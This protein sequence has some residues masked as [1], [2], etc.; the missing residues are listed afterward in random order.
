MN[1]LQRAASAAIVIAAL[2][3]CDQD[4]TSPRLATDA[5]AASQ[6][7]APLTGSRRFNSVRYGNSGAQRHGN[8]SG[9]AALSAEVLVGG[10]GPATFEATSHRAGGNASAGVIERVRLTVYSS[11]RKVL[12]VINVSGNGTSDL[13]VAL[14][15]LPAGAHVSA[16]A[17]VT[18]IDGRRTNVV[19]VANMQPVLRP[20]VAIVGLIIPDV[21]LAG[22][23]TVIGAVLAEQ[24]GARGASLD[25]VLYVDGAAADRARNVWV[26]AGDAVTCA[27]T[28]VF[29]ADAAIRVVAENVRPGDGDLSDNA[30]EDRLRVLAPGGSGAQSWF[31][32]DIRAGSYAATDS[33][34]TRWLAP[35]GSLFLEQVSASST[36]GTMQTVNVSGSIE[37]R[38]PFPLARIEI[39][40]NADGRLVGRTRLADVAPTAVVPGASCFSQDDGTGPFL[41]LCS[42]DQGFTSLLFMRH[43]GVVTYQSSE[44]SRVWN[45][46]SYDEN[47][48][49]V[50]QTDAS[51]TAIGMASHY[52]VNIRIASGGV[53]YGFDGSAALAP[54]DELTIEPPFCATVPLSLPPVT[55]QATSCYRSTWQFSGI[56]GLLAGAGLVT[57]P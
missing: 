32:G 43:A 30:A 12:D 14:P 29:S 16:T 21:A 22:A 31:S 3:A 6:G 18:G 45:G 2:S 4:S 55:Y 47:V 57:I 28:R 23:P 52:A 56:A 7:A 1:T 48:Y 17:L 5:L 50:N 8:R 37:A 51:G 44:Y 24:A 25:C 15:S 41:Y 20:D 39:T 19:T 49:V 9:S 11:A 53:L 35:D 54:L 13:A 38:L 36:N 27:F 40:E 33:F 10:A 34:S 46:T 42:E 26:D